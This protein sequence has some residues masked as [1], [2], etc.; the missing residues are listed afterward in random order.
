MSPSVS[1]AAAS[2]HCSPRKLAEDVIDHPKRYS[3]TG[4]GVFVTQAELICL[5]TILDATS[6]D[7]M[8]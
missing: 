2:N 7:V 5:S 1:Q 3:R 4:R 8:D 6:K